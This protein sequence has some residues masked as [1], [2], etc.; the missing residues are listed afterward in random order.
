MSRSNNKKS[1]NN[2]VSN[3]S[4][5]Y[6]KQS[7]YK[8]TKD[9]STP[10]NRVY[11]SN[12]PSWYNQDSS[13]A[14]DSASIPFSYVV[15]TPTHLSEDGI[16]WTRPGIM[17]LT[18]M[19]TIGEASTP[20][21]PINIAATAN[22]SFIRHAN[23]G[24]SNYDAPDLMLYE[25][26]LA[27]AYSYLNYLQ[28]IY[29]LVTLYSTS[30]RYF[31]KALLESDFI[32]FNDINN[33]L[34]NFRYGIN[35]FINKLAAF[36][37]QGDMPYFKRQA[38]LYSNVYTQGDSAKSS[39]YYY[40]PYGFYL[41]GLN[42]DGSGML[43]FAKLEAA[44]SSLGKYPKT[45]NYLLGYANRLIDPILSSE[46][47]GIMSGDILRAYGNNILKVAPI[48][49][50][51]PLVPMADLAVIEQMQNATI[52][53]V[54]P[55]NITQDPT[56]GF[57]TQTIQFDDDEVFGGDF[58]LTAGGGDL[59]AKLYGGKRLLTTILKQPTSDDVLERTRLMTACQDVQYDH[60]THRL[61]A[62]KIYCGTEIAKFCQIYT[63][64]GS[65]L[66]YT[67]LGYIWA[68]VEPDLHKFG[69][70]SDISTFSF[71]PLTHTLS[72]IE[73]EED[74]QYTGPIGIITDYAALDAD[75]I[76][77]LHQTATL[78]MLHVVGNPGSSL[79]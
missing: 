23:S 52:M 25:L 34:A 19:P 68:N 32:D 78:S 61:T 64:S 55:A 72:W 71:H 8:D 15:G 45:V 59:M 13:L 6:S 35:V 46:D 48:P 74:V 22:Y 29:G 10:N 56:H 39:L 42:S 67:D 65:E 63:I 53:P 79:R 28:R 58:W 7:T 38:F 69:A 33:N 21:S 17:K 49:E 2:K 16:P 27:N 73:G 77:N 66:S 40:T 54:D 26:A 9:S 30:N 51:Y 36:A 57:L 24:H 41:Y 47:M 3:R 12:D 76:Y 37:V 14:R 20:N 31:P 4:Q 18:L 75:L 43:K 5:R 50:Y 11:T 70:L 1:N 60:T 44:N 62:S